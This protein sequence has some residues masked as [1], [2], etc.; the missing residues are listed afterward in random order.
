MLRASVIVLASSLLLVIPGDAAAWRWYRGNSTAA[1]MNG[2][3]HIIR[4]EGRAERAVS[5]ARINNEEARSRFIDNQKKWTETYFAKKE[6]NQAYVDKQMS[7]QRT[8]RDNYLANRTS[9]APQRLS[10]SQLDQATG[11]IAWPDGLKTPNFDAS[12][13][14][15]EDLFSL[16]TRSLVT[17]TLSADI[18]TTADTMRG[19]L[20]KHMDKMATNEYLAARKFIDSLAWE[21]STPSG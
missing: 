3:A 7:K 19:E 9:A 5:Q 10:L 13:K 2:L 12:R 17:S 16:R 20:R 11:E 15:L 8:A 21:A 6:I 14:K 1:R 18:R 4:N